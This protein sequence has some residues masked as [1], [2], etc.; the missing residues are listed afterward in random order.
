[1]L[2]RRYHLLLTLSPFFVTP[3]SF[4]SSLFAPILIPLLLGIRLNSNSNLLYVSMQNFRAGLVWNSNGGHSISEHIHSTNNYYGTSSFYSCPL[5]PSLSFISL[6]SFPL[7]CTNATPGLYVQR[8]NGDNYI[9]LSG[10]EVL[11]LLH[12]IS[13]SSCFSS[14]FLLFLFSFVFL[15]LFLLLHRGI[16]WLA[17][18]S[19]L[20]VRWEQVI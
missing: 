17:L 2:L 4:S 19:L 7:A 1:M 18:G 6:F 14:F 8:S 20:T 5:P 12:F 16:L 13:L 10:L 11:L 9:G 3:L 15:Y